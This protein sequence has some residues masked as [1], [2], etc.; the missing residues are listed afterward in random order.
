MR[1]TQK[2]LAS[3]LRVTPAAVSQA[4]TKG[5]KCQGH[6]VAEWTE[7]RGGQILWYEV[8]EEA[9]LPGEET[10]SG[11]QPPVSSGEEIAEEV[12]ASLNNFDSTKPNQ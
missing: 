12:S 5:H 9:T 3:R 7:R 1:L 8:P 6:P 10:A 2:E 11:D 4:T